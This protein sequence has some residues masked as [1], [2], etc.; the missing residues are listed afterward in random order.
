MRFILK[1]KIVSHLQRKLNVEETY[2]VLLVSSAN[3]LYRNEKIKPFSKKKSF[4][5]DQVVKSFVAVCGNQS[6][7]EPQ[8]LLVVQNQTVRA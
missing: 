5:I 2:L 4:Q 7:Y 8:H 3:N 1:F 6:S